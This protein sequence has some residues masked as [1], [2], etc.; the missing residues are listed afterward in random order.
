MSRL[1]AINVSV[2]LAYYGLTLVLFPW[3]ILSLESALG[4]VRASSTLLDGASAV[5]GA[6]GAALQLWSI[7]VLQVHG[8]GTPSPAFR[9][10]KML[11][12]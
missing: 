11:V 2:N 12:T 6:A 8:R 9:P 4:I 3:V 7:A 5:I 10:T 1:T